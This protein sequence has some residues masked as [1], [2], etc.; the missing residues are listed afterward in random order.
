MIQT[1]T[2]KA[3]RFFHGLLHLSHFLTKLP[4][5]RLEFKDSKIF[6]DLDEIRIKEAE[7]G[8]KMMGRSC[9]RVARVEK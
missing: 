4:Y 9:L 8:W 3:R 2:I 5:M 6:H 1:N 7:N